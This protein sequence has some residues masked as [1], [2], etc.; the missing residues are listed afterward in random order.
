M[1]KKL[2]SILL[3][4]AMVVGVF[5][6]LPIASAV[7]TNSNSTENT[8]TKYVTNLGGTYTG[9]IKNKSKR[10]FF[11]MPKEW[12]TFSNAT[13]CAYWWDG[14]DSCADW[15]NSYEMRPTTIIT[16]DG[17]KVYY[18]D[19]DEN[20]TS[21]IFNNGIDLG[22]KSENEELPPNYGKACQTVTIGLE[23]YGPN[24]SMTYP[25]GLDSMNNMIYVPNDI[26]D[27]SLSSKVYGGEWYYLH[28]D[29][30]WDTVKGSVYETKDVNVKLDKRKD[31]VNIGGTI[32]LNATFENLSPDAKITW[33]SSDTNIAT[34]DNNG[35][36]YGV[37]EG[38]AKIKISVQNPGETTLLCTYCTV[39]VKS[40]LLGIKI[41]KLP[42]KT[43]YYEGEELDSDIITKGIEVVAIYSGNR[44][45]VL[46]SGSYYDEDNPNGYIVAEPRYE[47]GKN[48]VT[49]KYG[50][51]TDTFEITILSKQI[52][53]ITVYPPEKL[54]YVVGEDL[55]ID[56]MDVIA[57]YADG[58]FG[59]VYDYS[60]GDYDF[61]T[62]G[63]KIIE[64]TC[65]GQ[66]GHF[67]VYVEPKDIDEILV[68]LSPD[69]TDYY[70]GD[71]IDSSDIEVYIQYADGSLEETKDYYLNYDFSTA[72]KKIVTVSYHNYR[73]SFVVNVKSKTEPTTT[74]PTTTK[75]TVKKVTKVEVG[76]KSVAL[77]N[78]RS[79]TV[80]VK[81]SPTDATNKKLKWTT[82]NAKVATVNQS[83]KITAKGRG[84]AT[85]KVMAIDGINIYATVKVTVK[86]P[87]TSV[88]LNRKSANLKVKGSSKQKTVT[89]KATVYPKNTNNKAVSWKSSNSKIATVNRKG[90][91]TAKKKG[92]CYITATAKDGSKKSAKCKIVVK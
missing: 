53:G 58:T 45:V 49:I 3:S 1:S 10:F 7:E 74:Q 6:T 87:V 89:L 52:K 35:T 70:V 37:D 59:N 51:F 47:V 48:T 50:G 72:G 13:A 76:K 31:T 61:S 33:S 26:E 54:T 23:C 43:T 81:V 9:P 78:G 17:S 80:K 12:Y 67:M 29:G 79:T 69:R 56:G 64:V 5:T 11:A 24:E 27:E 60:I 20:I 44:K 22:Q 41:T 90:K 19:I 88:K 25:D 38:T 2:I 39:E 82:S 28:S 55:D 68:S 15:Q 32:Q 30:K 84:T 40:V 16:D 71:E 85:I 4:V 91:V 83:G 86:Q 14:E 63:E 66:K 42:S 92:T 46:N 73:K 75:P 36:V 62:V 34:V 21:I 65:R 8:E 77:L 18:I 57:D